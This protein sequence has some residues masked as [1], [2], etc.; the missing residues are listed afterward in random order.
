MT[1]R[2]RDALEGFS[3]AVRVPGLGAWARG[4]GLSAQAGGHALRSGKC[5]VGG[6]R[7]IPRGCVRNRLL[8]STHVSHAYHGTISTFPFTL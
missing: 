5:Y 3:D 1:A 6:F 7:D 2:C 4:L 8:V